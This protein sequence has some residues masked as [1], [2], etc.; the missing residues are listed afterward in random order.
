MSEQVATVH[1]KFFRDYVEQYESWKED[2]DKLAE[3]ND[4]VQELL[5]TVHTAFS[6]TI[7]YI[8]MLLAKMEVITARLY[9]K[10][11]LL[12]LANENYHDLF[13]RPG[14]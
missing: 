6:P 3:L 8:S 9:F 4:K 12:E 2:A 11:E 1:A 10:S 7:P 14:L 5:L 13:R